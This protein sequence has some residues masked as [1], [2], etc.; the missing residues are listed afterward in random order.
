MAEKP[1]IEM[2]GA[3][4]LAIVTPPKFQSAVASIEL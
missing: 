2:L 4:M 3:E 1:A